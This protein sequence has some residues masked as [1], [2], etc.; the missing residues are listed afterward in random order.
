MFDS[1]GDQLA[2]LDDSLKHLRDGLLGKDTLLL[3]LD[4][5]VDV[6]RAALGSR[7]LH[8]QAILGQV[9]LPRLG[10]IK[11]DRRSGSCDL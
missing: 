9:N 5:Q 1:G 11:L 8:D 7:D 10:G 6:D 2:I 4:W 3:S